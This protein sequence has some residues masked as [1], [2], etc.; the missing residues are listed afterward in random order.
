MVDFTVCE[1][2]PDTAY[3]FRLVVSCDVYESALVDML[4]RHVA[5]GTGQW[6]SHCGCSVAACVPDSPS[7]DE[8]LLWRSTA[9]VSCWNVGSC[10]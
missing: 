1:L 8:Q 9:N 6:V 2:D 10:C 5:P 3:K 4:R 7:A